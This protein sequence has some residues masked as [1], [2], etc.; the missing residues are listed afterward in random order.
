MPLRE[1]RAGAPPDLGQGTPEKHRPTVSR[2]SRELSAGSGKGTRPEG[3]DVGEAH[4]HPKGPVDL[5]GTH[6]DGRTPTRAPL[7]CGPGVV[8]QQVPH[9]WQASLLPASPLRGTGLRW[10]G[11]GRCTVTLG[12]LLKTHCSWERA[13]GTPHPQ[14]RNKTHALGLET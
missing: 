5:G 4:S 1:E 9:Q 2:N 12:A 3:A 14:Q 6:R 10:R 13:T 8:D 11:K 7:V